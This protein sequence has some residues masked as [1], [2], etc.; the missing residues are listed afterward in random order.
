MS[1]GRAGGTAAIGGDGASIVYTPPAGYTGE[2][3]FTYTVDGALKAEVRVS[4]GTTVEEV[5]PQ[6]DSLG[7]FEQFLLDDALAR[8]KDLFGKS[9]TFGTFFDGAGSPTLSSP[10]H[11]E[12]NVQVMGVDEADH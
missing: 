5:L 3:T 9:G 8:Y 2:E 7:D 4:V 6:F 1:E 12:T 10:G 11:S